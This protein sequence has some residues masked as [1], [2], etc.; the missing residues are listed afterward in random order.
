MHNVTLANTR[1]SVSL[2]MKVKPH[3]RPAAYA[4]G[5]LLIT[6]SA[7]VC[8]W[9]VKG[10]GWDWD[11]VLVLFAAIALPLGTWRTLSGH[12]Q[13][14]L[15]N[16]QFQSIESDGQRRK[17]QEA[18]QALAQK[19][20]LP[21]PHP[22]DRMALI[23]RFGPRNLKDNFIRT[24]ALTTIDGIVQSTPSLHPEIMNTLC[25]YILTCAHENSYDNLA[26]H[27]TLEFNALQ[28]VFNELTKAWE[29]VP[30]NP[31]PSYH[32]KASKVMSDIDLS[33][34]HRREEVEHRDSA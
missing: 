24:T 10:F 31:L 8:T 22:Q 18:V 3:Q 12:L 7:L 11:A 19:T 21:Q 30:H 6:S 27:T 28:K 33:R 2:A 17:L 26:T 14:D 9:A 20:I 23:S 32:A 5:A 15:A 16:K 4:F 34:Q 1:R 25:F 29:S 13:V